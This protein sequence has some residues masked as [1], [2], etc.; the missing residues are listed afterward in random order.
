MKSKF[1]AI[2]FHEIRTPIAGITSLSELMLDTGLDSEQHEIANK[3]QRSAN[4]LLTVINDIQDFNKAE[5]GCLDIEEVQFSLGIVLQ[6][7]SKMLSFA[8]DKKGIQFLSDIKLGEGR[9]W[10]Y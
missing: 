2:M 8:A 4:S 3:V 6:D 9:T 1:L 10:C 7:V 5:S